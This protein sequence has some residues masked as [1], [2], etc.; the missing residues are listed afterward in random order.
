MQPHRTSRLGILALLAGA[1]GCTHNYYY[2]TMPICA[3]P[4]PSAAVI[5]TPATVCEVPTQ[6]V[7]GTVAQPLASPAPVVISEPADGGS[8]RRLGSRLSW[9]RADPENLATTEVE[10]A[11]DDDTIRQ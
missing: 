9:R 3:E 4:A 5:T 10:G 7:G 8:L 1:A 11:L 6:V 2:G